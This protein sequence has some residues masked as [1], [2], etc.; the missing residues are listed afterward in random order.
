MSPEE[1][2][3]DLGRMIITIRET[4]VILD[5]DLALL[6]GVSTIAFNRAVKRNLDRFPESFMFQLQRQEFA[7]LRYQIGIS[8]T[9]GG[10]R[11]LPYV[12]T[13][14]GALMAANV[15]NSPKAVKMSVALIEAF[16]RLRQEFAT[17]QALAR[18]LA[19][20]ERTVINHDV[21][22]K[23]LFRVIKP[24]LTPPPDPPRKKIGFHP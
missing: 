15:L 3:H 9:R 2:A 12:F 7:D 21:A 14:H 6:Y 23:E 16:V 18:R 24:M 4:K 5:S 19:E 1:A 13:E 8:N 11:Y 20:I 10:R 17:T 22:L